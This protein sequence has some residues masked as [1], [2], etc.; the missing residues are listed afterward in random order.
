M[1]TETPSKNCD[2]CN[3][4]KECNPYSPYCEYGMIMKKIYGKWEA[5][6]EIVP[7][8]KE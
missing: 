5:I 7:D 8:E 1:G 4:N 2:K 6:A 3:K